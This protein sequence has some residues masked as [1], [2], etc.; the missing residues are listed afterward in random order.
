M[1]YGE[2]G[3]LEGGSPLPGLNRSWNAKFPRRVAIRLKGT[4]IAQF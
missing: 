3:M 4:L 2:T 1:Y